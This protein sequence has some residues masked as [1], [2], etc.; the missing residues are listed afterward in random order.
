MRGV[1]VC[2]PDSIKKGKI[3]QR[4]GNINKKRQLRK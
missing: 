4:R 1:C 2:I 3:E